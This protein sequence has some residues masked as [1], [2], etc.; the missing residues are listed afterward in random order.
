MS[1]TCNI[2]ILPK[3]AFAGDQHETQYYIL[4]NVVKAYHLAVSDF[5][6]CGLRSDHVSDA[7]HYKSMKEAK[8]HGCNISVSVLKVRR[9]SQPIT[10]HRHIYHRRG[11]RISAGGGPQGNDDLI[12]DGNE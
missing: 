8:S 4:N 10:I 6:V 2:L 5:Y 3:P 7:F 9:L 1:N 12:W 11:S